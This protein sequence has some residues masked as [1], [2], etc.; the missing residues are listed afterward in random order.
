M[1]PT[2]FCQTVGGPEAILDGEPREKT[3]LRGGPG[4][5]DNFPELARKSCEE[6]GFISG[7]GRVAPVRGQR[8]GDGVLGAR[9]QLDFRNK[10]AQKGILFQVF[11]SEGVNRDIRNPVMIGQ[12]LLD[13]SIFS[14]RC[15]ENQGG[16][17]LWRGA[18]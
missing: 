4:L 12:R 10:I 5:P 9:D 11:G 15:L 1:G 3:A 2:P 14:S 6:L 8:P 17:V 13:C 7:T 16:K 18:M